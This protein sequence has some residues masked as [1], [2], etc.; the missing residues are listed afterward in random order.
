VM[1]QSLLST[2]LIPAVAKKSIVFNPVQK[3]LKGFTHIL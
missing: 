3:L 2:S 1:S